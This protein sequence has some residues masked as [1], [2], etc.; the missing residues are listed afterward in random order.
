MVSLAHRPGARGQSHQIRLGG[1]RVHAVPAQHLG[2]HALPQV[3][4]TC[5]KLESTLYVL[6]YVYVSAIVLPYNKLYVVL[7]PQADVG[8]WPGRDLAGA[9]HHHPRQHSHGPLRPL[10][11]SH[12]HQRTG[13]QS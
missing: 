5:S 9:S 11:V 10:H 2:H 6:H 4:G 13:K 7:L 8:G 1:G 12:L 3:C